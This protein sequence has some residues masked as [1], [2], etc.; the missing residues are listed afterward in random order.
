MYEKI[1]V[2]LDGSM[3]SEEVLPYAQEM[4]GRLGSEVTLICVTESAKGMYDHMWQGYLNKTLAAVKQGARQYI[5][6]DEERDIRIKSNLLSGDPADEIVGFADTE[7]VG[8]ILMS[9]RGQSGG[10]TRWNIGSVAIKV[11]RATTKPVGLIRIK[12]TPPDLRDIERRVLIPLDGSKCAEQIIPYV[13]KFA[14]MRQA[15][16]ILLQ[17][18]GASY[19]MQSAE[20]FTVINYETAEMDGIKNNA[21]R[22]LSGVENEMKKEGLNIQTE[23]RVGNAADEIIKIADDMNITI[24][25]MTT[26]GRSGISR[27]AFGSVTNRVLQGGYHPMLIVRC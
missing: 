12:G 4:A 10:D 21:Q 18:M 3:A 26:H 23:I 2:P 27:W 24:I 7:N 22:Y 13:K 17:V 8:L 20:G 6:Q 11:L 9:A 25:A 16:I 15:K 14:A 5:P 19:G 1:L